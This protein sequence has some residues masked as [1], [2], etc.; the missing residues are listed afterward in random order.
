[1]CVVSPRSWTGFVREPRWALEEVVAVFIQDFL[2]PPPR[3]F[4]VLVAQGYLTVKFEPCSVL[5]AGNVRAV[6]GLGF[7]LSQFFTPGA[8]IHALNS[9][10]RS[11]PF[12]MSVF[13]QS[14]TRRVSAFCFH[15]SHIIS[16]RGVSQYTRPR[17]SSYASRTAGSVRVPMVML[18]VEMMP[19]TSAVD[20]RKSYDEILSPSVRP[21]Q[22]FGLLDKIGRVNWRIVSAG[23]IPPARCLSASATLLSNISALSLTCFIGIVR[24]WCTMLQAATHYPVSMRASCMS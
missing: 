19:S 21:M 13:A 20:A 4:G 1:M 22:N 23:R 17:Q 9:W 15:R 12:A 5:P 2:A 16:S 6:V 10:L 8:A 24:R 11:S 3:S 18:H 7:H 14:C